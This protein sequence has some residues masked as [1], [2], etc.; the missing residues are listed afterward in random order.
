MKKENLKK[1]ANVILGIGIVITLIG[2]IYIAFIQKGYAISGCFIV[3]SVLM[4]SLIV[5]NRKKKDK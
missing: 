4:Y 3:S 2:A 1:I 5:S